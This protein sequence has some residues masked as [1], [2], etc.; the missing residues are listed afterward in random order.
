MALHGV[1]WQNDV[2]TGRHPEKYKGEQPRPNWYGMVKMKQG[3]RE[4]VSW[5]DE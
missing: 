4:D 3:I 5:G 1:L 2:G